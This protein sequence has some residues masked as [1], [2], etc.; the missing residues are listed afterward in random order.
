MLLNID[1]DQAHHVP[2]HVVGQPLAVVDAE[3]LHALVIEKVGQQLGRDEEVLARVGLAGDVD[4]RVVHRALGAGVH[5]LVDLV[6]E[7]EGRACVLRQAHEVQDRRERTFLGG[8]S[9]DLS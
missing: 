3:D 2:A 9:V 6:D 5:A 1:V 7:R 4:E 8:R